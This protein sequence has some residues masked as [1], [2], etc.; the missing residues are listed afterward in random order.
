MNEQQNMNN[1]TPSEM[2]I[3]RWKGPWA[4]VK[5]AYLKKEKPEMWK[6]L[7]ETG[8]AD[9]YLKD[10]EEE[11][12]EKA[13]R[14][15]NQLMEQQGATEELKRKDQMKWIGITTYAQHQMEEIL[16]AELRQ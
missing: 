2:E 6:E 4:C 11:Y 12:S 8:K 9:E 13:T 15:M 7:V 3:V 14:L 16:E 1:P 5:E 10:I